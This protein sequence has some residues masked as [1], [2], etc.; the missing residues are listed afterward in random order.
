MHIKVERLKG[1][2]TR[3]KEYTNSERKGR[4]ERRAKL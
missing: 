3:T 4:D 1:R 2:R